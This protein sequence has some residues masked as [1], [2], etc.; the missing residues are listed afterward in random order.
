MV[1]SLE[2][3]SVTRLIVGGSFQV[4]GSALGGLFWWLLGILLSR[5]DTGIGPEGYGIY[6]VLVS[7]ISFLSLFSAGISI[8][9][10]RSLQE[11]E[12]IKDKENVSK[13]F[14]TV[15]LILLSISIFIGLLIINYFFSFSYIRTMLYLSLISIFILGFSS[16]FIGLLNGFYEYNHT[17]IATMIY[18]AGAFASTTFLLFVL[19]IKKMSPHN[20]S[21]YL[22]LIF[23]SGSSFYLMY[24]LLASLITIPIT[25]SFFFLSLNNSFKKAMRRTFWCTLPLLLSLNSY[26]WASILILSFF[27][28][29]EKYLGMLN[30][31]IG[32]ATTL[33]LI[34]SFS[35]PSVPEI[36]HAYEAGNI[37]LIRNLVRGAVKSFM[38]LTGVLMVAYISMSYPLLYIFHTEAYI[39]AQIPFIFSTISTG[40]ITIAYACIMILIGLNKEKLGGIL[41]LITFISS[42]FLFMVSLYF[43][44]KL[45]YLEEELNYITLPSIVLIFVTIPIVIYL[46]SAIK[47][48]SGYLPTSAIFK[49]IL[50]AFI[51]IVIGMMLYPKIWPKTD[52]IQLSIAAIIPSS[53]YLLVLL[54]IGYFDEQD[55]ILAYNV[56]DSLKLSFLSPIIKVFERIVLANPLKE[57]SWARKIDAK[58]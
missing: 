15:T 56:I 37:N 26:M 17:G 3:K 32:Y 34:A 24:L 27:G 18:G 19:N 11:F 33:F 25:L 39:D 2:E 23:I 40:L 29:D 22:A 57:K 21:C 53:L 48:N 42:V 7:F 35:I 13:A 49:S 54:L 43:D 36:G 16:F 46:F 30:I 9:L 31:A 50:S 55:F 6:G 1:L 51:A 45:P 41:A 38:F 4:I 58:S 20:Y 8:A 12:D 5:P 44:I 47:E 10:S 14:F 52:F 28:V